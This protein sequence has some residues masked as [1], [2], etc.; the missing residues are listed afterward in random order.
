MAAAL[1]FWKE[2]VLCLNI[3]VIESYSF[4]Q[5]DVSTIFKDM[6]HNVFRYEHTDISM[7]NNDEVYRELSE[8]VKYNSID[9]VFSFNYYPIVSYVLKDTKVKYIS[10]V[11]DSPHIAV[12]TYSIMFSCNYVFLF[13]YGV[14]EELRNGGITTVYYLPL[15]VN[16]TRLNKVIAK[17]DAIAKVK[18]GGGNLLDVS[19]VGGLYNE[20]H[21][22]YDRLYEKLGDSNNYVRGYLDAL[23]EAQSHI[24]GCFFLDKML[25]DSILRIMDGV[26]PYEANKDSI[27]TVSYV[28]SHYFMARK[29][30]EIERIRILNKVSEKYKL[31]LFT[32]KEPTEVPKAHFMGSVD[33]YKDMPIV[34]NRSKINLNISL[35][36]ILTG[37]PLRCIDVMGSGGFLLTNYQADMFRH[38][39]AGKHFDYYTDEDDLLRKVEYYLNHEDERMC[40]AEAGKNMINKNHNLEDY[41]YDMLS[42]VMENS[43]KR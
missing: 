2:E 17:A 5:D 20:K 1:F 9:V 6:G 30:T 42:F 13:D 32:Y 4:G 15:S 22:L 40:I 7:H 25:D 16:C 27:A 11:Y 8:N 39:E 31:S 35:K 3:L 12:Y 38:F 36:S 24:Q 34:F 29:V 19:F 10:Y 28:Y 26:Y 14:Y 18:S 21:K 33:Y 43:E 23:V 41:L 37:I